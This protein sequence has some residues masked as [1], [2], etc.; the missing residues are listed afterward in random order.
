MT[1]VLNIILAIALALTG[2]SVAHA[3][4]ITAQAASTQ[5]FVNEPL[6]VSVNVINLE[7]F[8]GPHF[9]EVPGLEIKR[10]PGEQTSTS[11]SNINGR[12]TQQR[13]V[14]LS[15]EVLATTVGTFTIP[16][17]TVDADGM[18]YS[19][20]AIA[21]NITASDAAILMFARVTGTPATLYIGQ[22]GTL[23]LEL[24]VKRFSDATLGITLDEQSIWSLVSMDGSSWGVFGPTL[25]KMMSE[26]RRPRG[27][28]RTVDGA[29][30]LVFTV[31][32]PFDP[33]ATGTPVVGDIRLRMEYPTRLQ[34]GSDFVF[35]NR[36]SLAGSR[37]LSVMP[38]SI[39]A[40][41]LP[42]PEGGRPAQ[43]NGAVGD[44]EILVVAKPNEV[45]VGDPITIT[46]RLTD[47]SS[48]AAL[49][50][51]QAPVLANQP[52]FADG[53]RVPSESASGTVE[54]RS[55][56]FTQSLRA[57]SETVREIP[58]VELS[59]FNP[60]KGAYETVRSAPIPLRVKPSAVVRIN[61]DDAALA[62]AASSKPTFTKVE[63]GLLANASVDEC[64]TRATVTPMLMLVTAVLPV[65]IAFAPAVV[66]RLRRN[67][68]PRAQRHKKALAHF[69][70]LLVEGA[71]AESIESTLIAFIARRFGDART[72]LA[73]KDVLE[74]LASAK[75]EATLVEQTDQ[76]LRQCERARYLGG[77]IDAEAARALA[78]KLDAATARVEFVASEVEP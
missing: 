34:R 49:E 74:L 19:T 33:I 68:D 28:L 18:R 23:N 77:A 20:K 42:L 63:G 45:S 39:E 62:T 4:G 69:E 65:A 52:A 50:G 55:K 32:K 75:V 51:L 7:S 17:F 8:D 2:A 53:F 40:S 15:F 56:I 54:G 76:L 37:T 16:P 36:L 43:W 10:L 61:T 59:F 71:S 48:T 60:A 67:R 3:Q 1:R 27:E 31:A 73:R 70:I 44:F 64:A 58:S 26:N 5:G 30:Y 21:I 66:G 9:T 6:R 12:A 41:I 24:F 57:L 35:Q 38:K 78:R 72:G 14:S 25:Q 13:T 46:M 11:F 22:Q 47:N 29:E